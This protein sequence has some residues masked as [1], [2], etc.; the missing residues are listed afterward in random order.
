MDEEGE[1]KGKEENPGR[2]LSVSCDSEEKGHNKGGNPST[3][4]KRKFQSHNKNSQEKDPEKFSPDGI[5][6]QSPVSLSQDQYD[7]QE[8]NH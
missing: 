6:Y 5:P 7:S 4:I 1:E 8:N 2:Y 3:S